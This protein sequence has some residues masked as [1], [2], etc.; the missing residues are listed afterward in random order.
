MFTQGHMNDVYVSWLAQLGQESKSQESYQEVLHYG[1]LTLLISWNKI[2]SIY[3]QGRTEVETWSQRVKGIL[4]HTE[5]MLKRTL[6]RA[7]LH[8]FKSAKIHFRATKTYKYWSSFDRN[9][10]ASVMKL[11]KALSL[12]YHMEL[13]IRTWK[14]RPDF[15]KFCHRDNV[16]LRYVAPI[17]IIHCFTK[18]IPKAGEP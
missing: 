13:K 14:S 6:S 2:K 9:Y 5:K 12:R 17:D 10:N 18:C 8:K 4:G 7:S 16:P 1:Y 15:S 11:K 3:C